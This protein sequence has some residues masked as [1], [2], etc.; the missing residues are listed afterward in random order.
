MVVQGAT[1]LS[2]Y[3]C[4]LTCDGSLIMYD[5]SVTVFS[6]TGDIGDT[7]LMYQPVS[8]MQ[9]ILSGLASM[10]PDKNDQKYVVLIMRLDKGLQF[11]NCYLLIGFPYSNSQ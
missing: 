8:T 9:R 2:G 4:N 6:T 11:A 3:A 1:S 7:E 10:S 5:P